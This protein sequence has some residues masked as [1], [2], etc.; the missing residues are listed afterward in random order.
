MTDKQPL[1]SVVMSVYNSERYL[2]ESVESIL[3]QTFTDFEFIIIDDGSVDKSNSILQSFTDPRIKVL[4]NNKNL[5][6]IVSLNKGF[7]EAKGKYIARMDADDV[8]LPERLQ[9]QVKFLD[10][11]PGIGVVGTWIRSFDDRLGHI[12]KF[13]TDQKIIKAWL[14]FDNT[15]A[16]PSAMLRRSF[17][18]SYHLH[19]DPNF[20]HVE[21]YDLWVR[22][23]RFFDIAT[24]GEVLLLYRRHENSISSSNRSNQINKTNEIR[25][26][27]LK[28]M[29]FNPSSKEQTL[30]NIVSTQDWN[31]IKNFEIIFEIKVWLNKLQNQN[32][33]KK[34]FDQQSLEYVISKHWF[35]MSYG[36]T[37]LGLRVAKDYFSSTLKNYY[38]PTNK[39]LIKFMVKCLLKKGLSQNNNL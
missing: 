32:I 19:Y 27:Q 22:S 17:L 38:R 20:K 36:S 5:G 23:S 16:H 39:E 25:L 1:V 8:S 28:D 35:L 13:P 24:I 18:K 9:K 6:L 15:F 37:K 10:T 31:A 14:L 2:R 29:G 33:L 4:S 30:H 26:R 7:D 11:N 21:D 34:T 12:L 3:S